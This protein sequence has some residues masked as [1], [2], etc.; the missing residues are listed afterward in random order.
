MPWPQTGGEPVWVAERARGLAAAVIVA[1][2]GAEVRMPVVPLVE[3]Q[4]GSF[5]ACWWPG[6]HRRRLDVLRLTLPGDSPC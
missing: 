3:H 2:P 4:D 6:P 1:I 5:G